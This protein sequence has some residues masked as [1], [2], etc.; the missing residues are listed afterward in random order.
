MSDPRKF[1]FSDL[2]SNQSA[3]EAMLA[4]TQDGAAPAPHEV[5]NGT[6]EQWGPAIEK[7][8][9]EQPEQPQP[10]DSA[11]SGGL[12]QSLTS[13]ITGTEAENSIQAETDYPS[14]NKN[15]PGSDHHAVATEKFTDNLQKL[16]VPA[17]LA[18]AGGQAGGGAVEAYENMNYPGQRFG[19][20]SS[21]AGRQDMAND[22]MANAIGG[23][24]SL[25]PDFAQ[26]AVRGIGEGLTNAFGYEKGG[27][28][29][30]DDLPASLREGAAHL[31]NTSDRPEKAPGDDRGILK[32]MLDQALQNPFGGGDDRGGTA[33]GL[34]TDITSIRG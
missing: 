34:P 21:V 30:I 1:G 5:A 16:G 8:L 9:Q 24:S 12:M 4:M 6:D 28:D 22:F 27:R 7:L 18:F 33:I 19:G 17:G 20:N 29:P 31:F 25:A 15:F 3:L 23:L 13:A 11:L 2:P 32:F 26:P 10:I 14:M